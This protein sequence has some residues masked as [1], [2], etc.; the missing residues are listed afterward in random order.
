MENPYGDGWPTMSEDKVETK[1]SEKEC[2]MEATDSE[3]HS[4]L[5]CCYVIQDDD[6]YTNPCDIPADDCC[7]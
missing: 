4:N 6:S 3:G 7:R 1:K 2:R 5:C